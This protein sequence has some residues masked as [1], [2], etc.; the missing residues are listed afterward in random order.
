VRP[1]ELKPLIG[2][3]NDVCRR[4]LEAAAGATALRTHYNVEIEHF[5]IGLL[6]KADTDLAAILRR[7][8]IDPARLLADLTRSLDRMKTGNARAP[9]LS[10]DIP[11]GEARLVA[12]L[13][14]ARRQS[15][16]VRPPD[17]GVAG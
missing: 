5:L 17:V 8:E 14:G 2:R 1:I 4:A 6:D 13:G 12:G 15:R 9:S 7:W 11:D 16:A 3:L 10:P